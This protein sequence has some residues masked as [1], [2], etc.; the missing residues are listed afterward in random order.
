MEFAPSSLQRTDLGWDLCPT[1]N[2]MMNPCMCG[3]M[4]SIVSS[5]LQ[6]LCQDTNKMWKVTLRNDSRVKMVLKKELWERAAEYCVF[7]V[8]LLRKKE[9]AQAT[10]WLP[11]AGNVQRDSTS[12]RISLELTSFSPLYHFFLVY[13]AAFTPKFYGMCYNTP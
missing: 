3:S 2:I 8:H 6:H 7:K 5:I 13:N 9:K 12:N 4:H 11:C 10:D 1:D